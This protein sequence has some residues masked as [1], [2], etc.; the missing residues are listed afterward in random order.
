MNKKRRKELRNI[1]TQLEA[2]VSRLET[3]IDQEQEALDETPENLQS[4]TRYSD[5]EDCVNTMEDVKSD[6]E[7]A[8]EKLSDI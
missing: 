8:I 3:I 2:S 5:G 7:S 4:T 6:I 1:V